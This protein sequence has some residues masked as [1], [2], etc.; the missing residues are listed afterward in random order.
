[1]LD[2]EARAR[3]QAQ[4]SDAVRRIFAAKESLRKL[5]A[6][7]ACVCP[8]C[9]RVT[10]PTTWDGR[11]Y[12]CCGRIWGPRPEHVALPASF[13]MWAKPG[14]DFDGAIAAVWAESATS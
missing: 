1:M 4:V 5:P 8:S 3:L 12:E 7:T 14:D 9:K 6:T 11:Q 10:V 2:H 13:W